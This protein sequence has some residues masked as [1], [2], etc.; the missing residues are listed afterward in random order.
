MAA[1]RTDRRNMQAEEQPVAVEP[2]SDDSI[3]KKPQAI[4]SCK[5]DGGYFSVPL[6]LL[7]IGVAFVAGMANVIPHTTSAPDRFAFL[8]NKYD[9][10]L[11]RLV[12]RR[13]LAPDVSCTTPPFIVRLHVHV[14]EA[15]ADTLRANN[16][17]LLLLNGRNE[18]A[19]LDWPA[20]CLHALA[21]TAA[22]ALGADPDFFPNGLRLYNSDGGAIA[23]ADELDIE[24]LAYILMDFQMWVWPGIR[25]GYT[26]VLADSGMTMTTMS[27]SPLVYDV[28]GFFTSDEADAFIS[29]GLATINR[30][31]VA[32]NGKLY[33]VDDGM[34]TSDTAY[35]ADSLFTR[36]F[37]A[38]ATAV[39]RLPSPAFAERPQLIRYAPG[40]YFRKHADY[41]VV[42]LFRESTPWDTSKTQFKA[43][44]IFAAD[45]LTTK[46]TDSVFPIEILPGGPLFPNVSDT[47]TWQQNL[48]R[49]AVTKE[50]TFFTERGL[51]DWDDWVTE[52]LK[53][54]RA[55]N[56]MDAINHAVGHILP[57]LI[58][59]W[60]VH[61]A[62]DHPALRYVVPKPPVSGS[63]HYFRWIRWA[64]DRV[65]SLG[66]QVPPAFRPN[67]SDYPSLLRPFQNKLVKYVLADYDKVE[68][69]AKLTPTLADWLVANQDLDDVIV[70]CA[71]DHVV[72][73]QVAMEAWTNRAG[74]GLFAYD[75][76][77]HMQQTEPNRHLTL[78]LYLND[79][80]EGG[81]TVFT[82]SKERL[83]QTDTIHRGAGM[84][85]CSDGLIIPPRKLHAL[86]FYSMDGDNLADRMSTHAGCPPRSGIKYAVNMFT[87]NFDADEG[88]SALGY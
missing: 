5:K 41:Q 3:D 85:E 10:D 54:P 9:S 81:E 86:L 4:N 75:M 56:L 14:D 34:R 8:E 49:L 44:C 45:V 1:P 22:T 26:R 59:V 83:I 6:V 47:L 72:L 57:A 79:V 11:V 19:L 76:P 37:R 82:K 35:F 71:R 2:E 88:A 18:G 32:G 30:S 65:A 53:E 67:G 38:R 43:W 87:W 17:V 58:R 40:Q 84:D 61:A 25:V 39:S 70:D 31:M 21:E 29:Q 7:A 78:F 15:N 55:A 62:G 36:E 46:L 23:T 20:G 52:S 27:L 73:F 51:H 33:A 77:Q 16:H 48:L 68:L 60:E 50:P 13:V 74:A 66:D 12:P 63:A 24:R 69:D 80:A 42:N 64:K 28:E